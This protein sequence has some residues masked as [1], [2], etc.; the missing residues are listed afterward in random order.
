VDAELTEVRVL[1]EAPDRLHRRQGHLPDSRGSPVGPVLQSVR[2][3][4]EQDERLA[5]LRD[6]DLRGARVIINE[7]LDRQASSLEGATMPNG[8]LYEQE[9]RSKAPSSSL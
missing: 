6:A 2:V 9:G 3:R 5:D 1:L 4:R 8:Q 7:D